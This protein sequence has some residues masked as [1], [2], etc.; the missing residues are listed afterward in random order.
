MPKAKGGVSPIRR[1]Y[2]ELKRQ[3]PDAILFFRLGDFYETFDEDAHIV[4]R[5]LDITLTSRNVAKG[6][7]V[8][9][10]GVPYHAV[11]GYLARLLA[12]GYKVALAEQVGEPVKGLMPR[13]VVKVFT[14]GTVV[15]PELLPGDANNYLAAVVVQGNRAGIAYADVSTG[16]FAATELHG[17]AIQDLVRA[18]LLR[19][20]PAEV[21][22]PED[23]ALPEG[24]PGHRTP[25]PEWRFEPE[26]A[27]DALKT[28]FGVT[29]LAGF[30][31]EGKPLATRAAGAILQY[32]QEHRPDVLPLLTALRTYNLGQF[33]VLDAATR[34]GLEL[35]ETLRGGRVEGSL[36]GVLDRTVTPMGRRL[37]RQWVNQPLLDVARINRRLDGVA[38]FHQDP[39]TRADVRE[40]LKP[41]ADLERLVNRIAAGSAQPRDLVALRAT[42]RRIPQVRALLPEETHPVLGVLV[43]QIDPVDEA[44]QLLEQ[45]IADEPPATLQHI[46]VIRRGFSP[47]L[48]RIYDESEHAREWIANLEAVERQRTGIKSLKVGYNKVFGYYIEVTKANAHLVPKHYIRK[49][50][51]VNAERYITPEMKEYEAMVLHAEERIRELEARIFK[52]VVQRLAGWRERMLT[53]ARALAVLDVLASLAQVA[54][55]NDYVRPQVVEEPVLAIRDG[56]HPVVERSLEDARFVPNDAVFEDGEIVRILTGPNMSGKSTFL[57]QVAL[58]VLMAQMGSFV[59]A[60]EATIGVVD[61][62]F[63]RIGAQDEIHAGQ[64]TFM[65]EML[66]TAHILHHATPRS[67]VILDEVGRGTSTYD[68]LAIAWAIVEY[69]HNHPQLRAKTLFA[70]HYHELTQLADLLPGVRNYHVAVAEEGDRVVF[71]H[72]ILPGRADRSYGIHVAQLAGMP[73]AVIQRAQE[74]LQRLEA[75][76]QEAAAAVSSSARR[77]DRRASRAVQLSLFPETNPLLDELRQLDINNMTP[78][79]ALNLLYK[80]KQQWGDEG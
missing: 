36:L 45:A 64:S 31:L 17:E 71:L 48:D 18:E 80:W 35:T 25:W 56:R 42:L 73:R 8:P 20:A 2:L 29:H 60:R 57:R 70:T 10:A 74:I 6:V 30:G 28:H 22:H 24:I 16:E 34:R 53:T 67:L 13:K 79:E 40:A 11:D 4:S 27:R 47:E 33:M 12:K 46:G 39:I 77:H 1:Q 59:P 76:G 14:P 52:D 26:R 69:I 51:L 23:Q 62:I 41:L 3:Y 5:E 15:E 63:T 37:L 66:E 38:F 32:L 54:E 44:L 61:R 19:L 21:L 49:Q 7:R 72:R 43:R 78:I 65:V 75:A 9:M 50:T 58:I 55:E 68:G